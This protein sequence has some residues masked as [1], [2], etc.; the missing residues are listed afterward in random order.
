MTLQRTDQKRGTPWTWIAVDVKVIRLNKDGFGGAFI[1]PMRPAMT[2]L[3]HTAAR[4]TGNRA[5]KE[6]LERFVNSLTT[7]T[8]L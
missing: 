8:Q 3:A 6:T 2:G 1:P 7:S 5:S 4:G